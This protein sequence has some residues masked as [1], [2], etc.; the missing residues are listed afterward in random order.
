MTV[1][2]QKKEVV[3]KEYCDL[4]LNLCTE[5]VV[6]NKQ[7]KTKKKTKKKQQEA[8]KDKIQGIG[9]DLRGTFSK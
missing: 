7:N 6:Q 4:T 9:P 1:K 3:A 2:S 8:H 5:C